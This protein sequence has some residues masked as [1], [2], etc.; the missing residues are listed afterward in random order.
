[1]FI[2]D[3]EQA[4]K[5]RIQKLMGTAQLINTGG[6]FTNRNGNITSEATGIKNQDHRFHY[7]QPIL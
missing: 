6:A 3:K 5:E 2:K 1:M 7:E 4:E